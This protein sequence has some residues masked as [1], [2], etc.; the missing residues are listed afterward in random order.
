MLR[1]KRLRILSEL[2]QNA[3]AQEA[4]LHPNTI[5]GAET[6]HVRPYPRQLEAMA[7]ALGWTGAPEELLEEVEDEASSR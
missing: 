5:G 6:G 7:Q 1:L 3:L 4:G 2:S